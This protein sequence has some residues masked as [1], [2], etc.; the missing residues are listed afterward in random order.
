MNKETNTNKKQNDN[1]IKR[2]FSYTLHYPKIFIAGFISLILASIAVLLA[3]K[4]IG[5][6]IDLVFEKEEIYA[7]SVSLNDPLTLASIALISLSIARGCILFSQ[8]FLSEKLS[9]RIAFDL[10]NELFDHLQHMHFAYHDQIK[11]GDIMSRATQD[12]E[13]IR[14]FIS[15][16]IMRGSYIIFLGITSVILM[17]NTNT[18]LALIAFIFMPIVAI[19]AAIVQKFLRKI[20]IQIQQLQGKTSIVLQENFA[21]QQLVKGY[22]QQNNEQLKF[23]SVANQLYDFSLRSSKI[24]AFNEPMLS[25]VWLI[26]LTSIFYFGARLI[27]DGQITVGELVEF[28]LYLTLLQVP[29]RAIGFIINHIARVK[30]AGGRLFEIL[31]EPSKISNS[32]DAVALNNVQGSIIFENVSFDYQ[33]QDSKKLINNISFTINP[34]EKIGIIGRTGTG[35][36]TLL[37]LLSRFYD[38]NDGNIYIDNKNI[39]KITIKSLRQ[40]FGIVQQDIFLFPGTIKENIS[41]GKPDATLIEIKKAAT[42]AHIN[43]HIE[44]LP[45]QYETWV[46]ENGVSLSGGQKQRISIARTLLT[47]PPILILDDVTSSVDLKTELE[48]EKSLEKILVNKSSITVTHRTKVMKKLDKILFIEDGK[49]Q[50]QG[51]HDELYATN[52]KYRS[53]CQS[54]EN[55]NTKKEVR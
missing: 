23:N 15:M 48:I 24:V 17:L 44:S 32:K 25:G 39:K 36:S 43:K 14:F 2:V 46:G 9:Q 8:S 19:Q 37:H 42:L 1:I 38:I 31:D 4:L 30:S 10:R 20:W 33:K 7:F 12:I 27:L 55:K 52:Q 45:D 16:A 40:I 22:S 35:K 54:F 28:Q 34:G 49:I 51:K 47:N 26:A 5:I 11:I 18:Q 6:T 3:P 53:L 13:S 29:I 41:Y 50:D 21:G